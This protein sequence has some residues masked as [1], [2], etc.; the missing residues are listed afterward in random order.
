[1]MGLNTPVRPVTNG[2]RLVAI[3]AALAMLMSLM[4]AYSERADAHDGTVTWSCDG[5]TVDLNRYFNGASI[6][7]LEDG[8]VVESHAGWT[9]YSNSGVRDPGGIFSLQ[10][11]VDAY[12][13]DAQPVYN[14]NTAGSFSPNWPAGEF[15]F[16]LNIELNCGGDPEPT[17]SVTVIK[18]DIDGVEQEFNFNL[19]DPLGSS[20]SSVNVVD[21]GSHTWSDVAVGSYHLTEAA[22][23][24]FSL[25]GF[26]CTSDMDGFV[27][28]AVENLH[29]EGAAFVVDPGENITC[30]FINDVVQTQSVTVEKLDIDGVEQAF[31]FNLSDGNGVDNTVEVTDGVGSH[32][33]SVAAGTYQLTEAAAD[34]FTYVGWLCDSDMREGFVATGVENLHGR[35]A[36]FDLRPGENVTCSFINDVDPPD[37][38]TVTVT[39]KVV[40]PKIGNGEW[41]ALLQET[42]GDK[43]FSFDGDLVGTVRDGNSIQ[44]VAPVGQPFATR[45]S[46]PDGWQLT[47]IS[48]TADGGEYEIVERAVSMTVT[49]ERGSV[50]CTY[51]NTPELGLIVIEKNALLGSTTEAFDFAAPAIGDFIGSAPVVGVEIGGSVMAPVPVGEYE[52]TEVISDELAA[53]GWSFVRVVCEET[54]PQNSSTSGATA[55]AVVDFEE[56]VTCTW[57]NTQDEVLASI[58][59]TVGGD[60]SVVNE[61]GV[62]EITVTVSVADG[63]T[64][65][66]RD[67]EGNVVATV[68]NDAT[69]KV[70]PG[71]YV[72]Q[73]TAADGFEFPTGFVANGSLVIDDCTPVDELPLTGIESDVLFAL[74][75]MLLGSGL[76]LVMSSRRREETTS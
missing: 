16:T 26:D 73:A 37:P 9:S 54:G 68:T 35:G 53:Q 12:D 57:T 25:F 66:I 32:T 21:G 23:D 51:E 71:D 27:M 70:E 20:N 36:G 67:G 40:F 13:D 10:I 4:V 6:S 2:Q 7:I 65:E 47:N 43:L 41:D 15:S 46:I 17:Q 33:W 56:V 50:E 28:T 52:I 69:I 29:G 55:T 76:L 42:Y 63:A 64:V 58:L 19:G 48:C 38:G 3:F 18:A 34:G 62:G 61:E 24:G 45:E 74:S 39:K 44:E 72:W 30:R 11:V 5:W 8:S 31:A 1:M 14:Y 60:C 49:E 59:V 22:A 75:T